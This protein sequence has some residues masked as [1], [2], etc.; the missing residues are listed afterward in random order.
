M[1]KQAVS[2]IFQTTGN[3]H[4]HV[5]LRGGTRTGPNFGADQVEKVCLR[6]EARGLPPRLTVDCSHGNSRK[7]HR[8]QADVAAEAARQIGCGSE[9]VFGVMLESFLVEGCQEF[10]PGKPTVYGQ[11]ITDGCISAGQT[12]AILERLAEAQA[13]R[14]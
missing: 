4:C 10:V 7:D 9:R 8:K 3:R 2:A 13:K 11:S 5:I 14:G 6:L 12:E 1:T